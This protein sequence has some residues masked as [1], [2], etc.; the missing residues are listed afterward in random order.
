MNYGGAV[1]TNEERRYDLYF[2]SF[3]SK[4][5]SDGELSKCTSLVSGL[6]EN[7]RVI[8]EA[9]SSVD[10]K[11]V[12][13]RDK[14]KLIKKMVLDGIGVKEKFNIRP[15]K[16]TIQFEVLDVIVLSIVLLTNCY[17]SESISVS[18]FQEKYPKLITSEEFGTLYHFRNVLAVA[19]KLIPGKD[20]KGRLVDLVTRITEGLQPDGEPFK[21]I[22]GRGRTEE[23][24]SRYKICESEDPS[25]VVDR[26]KRKR[27]PEDPEPKIP[28]AR[29]R[30]K[31]SKNKVDV[32]PVVY[33]EA[34]ARI[35]GD[36]SCNHNFVGDMTRPRKKIKRCKRRPHYES[37]AA[38][39][40]NM[41]DAP[42]SDNLSTQ[43]PDRIGN[44]NQCDEEGVES[45][46]WSFLDDTNK[47]DEKMDWLFWNLQQPSQ[48]SIPNEFN[49]G[50]NEHMGDSINIDG[51]SNFD[52][53]IGNTDIFDSDTNCRQPSNS[54]EEFIFDLSSSF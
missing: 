51:F 14:M 36:S 15:N 11:T 42:P 30:P 33:D 16:R 13:G 18:E 2:N 44:T 50:D 8:V 52:N 47:F 10:I 25:C 6:C 49:S 38:A 53:I 48:S 34:K 23:T 39:I 37:S 12:F 45:L 3:L 7:E 35:N 43:D 26:S 17:I 41:S 40:V 21:Y 5:F 29:G 9:I 28:K 20:N 1:H 54:S 31:G 19:L 27:C 22:N 32:F 24:K 46:T 4:C